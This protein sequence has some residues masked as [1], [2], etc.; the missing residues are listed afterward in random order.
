MFCG[1][2]GNGLIRDHICVMPWAMPCRPLLIHSGVNDAFG[3]QVAW[4]MGE[5]GVCAWLAG[6]RA[7]PSTS[8]ARVIAFRIIDLPFPDRMIERFARRRPPASRPLR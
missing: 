7:R 1:R 5:V 3:C 2:A 6:H 4:G 8:A